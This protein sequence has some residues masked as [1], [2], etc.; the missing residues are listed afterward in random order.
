MAPRSDIRLK[1][2]RKPLKKN[3]YAKLYGVSPQTFRGW[4]KRAGIEDELGGSYMSPKQERIIFEA[5]DPPRGYED[6]LLPDTIKKF[7]KE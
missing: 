3:A 2:I 4:C 7:K 6:Y 1:P 5:L